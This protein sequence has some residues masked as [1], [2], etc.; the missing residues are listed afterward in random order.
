MTFKSCFQL[1]SKTGNLY[2][3]SDEQLERLAFKLGDMG[4]LKAALAE[5]SK[6]KYSLNGL[7]YGVERQFAAQLGC[8]N[9]FEL[10]CTDSKQK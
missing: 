6:G 10:F 8:S 1:K 3:L 2:V 4:N 9:I 7:S 5:T